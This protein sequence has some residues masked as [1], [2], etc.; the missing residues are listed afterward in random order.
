MLNATA[1]MNLEKNSR[2]SVRMARRIYWL[3]RNAYRI[4]SR[5]RLMNTTKKLRVTQRETLVISR[6][7]SRCKIT[8][9]KGMPSFSKTKSDTQSKLPRS[10][11]L[12]M[13]NISTTL[14]LSNRQSK[15]TPRNSMSRTTRSRC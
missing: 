15:N 6:G 7:T 2:E 1:R 11:L 5:G 8:Y 13:S 3:F 4:D 9:S 14:S 10:W 12:R